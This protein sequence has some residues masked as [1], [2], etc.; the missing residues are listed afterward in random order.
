MAI[1]RWYGFSCVNATEA[2]CF[3]YEKYH[4]TL[5]RG[6]DYLIAWYELFQKLQVTTNHANRDKHILVKIGEFPGLNF[7][8]KMEI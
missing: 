6:I 3:L 7:V 5:F 8:F 1:Y 2:S 4:N